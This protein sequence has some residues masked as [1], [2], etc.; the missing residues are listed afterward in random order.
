MAK[1]ELPIRLRAAPV[2]SYPPLVSP[3]PSLSCSNLALAVKVSREQRP[4]REIWDINGCQIFQGREG[5]CQ[6]GLGQGG[7]ATFHSFLE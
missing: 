3:G 5:A 1:E 4:R 2:P 7:E 6:D